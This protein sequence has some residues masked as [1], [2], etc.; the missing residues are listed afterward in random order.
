VVRAA[1][2]QRTGNALALGVAGS[3]KKGIRRAAAAL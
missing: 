2:R 3:I 1:S